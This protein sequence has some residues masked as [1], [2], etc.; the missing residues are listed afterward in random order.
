MARHGISENV[1]KSIPGGLAEAG[2]RAL[3]VLLPPQCLVCGTLVADPGTLCGACWG[4]LTFLDGPA[5]VRCGLPFEYDI[6]EEALCGGCLRLLPMYE[7]AR[8][9]FVYDDASR[10]LV[11]AFKHGDRTDFAPAFGRWL[12]RAGRPLL[13]DAQVIAPVPLHWTRLWRRRFNQAALMANALARVA[14]IEVVPDALKRRKRTPS[15]G[16]LGRLARKR[17]L[18]GAIV[19]PPARRSRI[20][21]KRVLV[22]D[23]VFTTGATADACARALLR[24]G[25]DSVDVLTLARVVRPGL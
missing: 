12:A 1:A 6:G 24:A 22:V 16:G 11:L 4:R 17:N 18:R 8:A 21:G 3:D 23:D 7:R 5:C 20:A 10:G 14:G 2:R 15:Q 9:V 25:A 19:C 13:A